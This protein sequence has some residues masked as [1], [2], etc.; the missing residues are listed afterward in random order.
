MTAGS[1]PRGFGADGP[2][3]GSRGCALGLATLPRDHWAGYSGGTV[4]TAP[5]RASG[6]PLRVSAVGGA[7][8]IRGGFVGDTTFSTANCDPITGTVVDFEVTWR[9]AHNISQLAYGAVALVFEVP[10]DATAF[11][12]SL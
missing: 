4:V 3:F 11:A 12:F 6:Q 5:V 2:F 10:D 8:G 7:T 1:D 9:G